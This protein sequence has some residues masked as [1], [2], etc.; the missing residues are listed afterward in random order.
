MF[1][2]KKHNFKNELNEQSI[3]IGSFYILNYYDILVFFRVCKTTKK[4][5]YLIELGTKKYKD[6]IIL[7]K[8][9]KA[10]KKP[11]VILNNNTWQKST[12]EVFP[13][14]DGLPIEIEFGSKLYNEALK[15]TDFPLCGTVYAELIQDIWKWYWVIEEKI[16]GIA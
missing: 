11:L 3:I 1:K 16:N 9:F 13:Q 14:K 4:S 10:S 6:G 12:Y 2:I 15:R 5:V 7:T 8:G